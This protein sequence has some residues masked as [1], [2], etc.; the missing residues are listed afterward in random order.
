M[1]INI[2][3]SVRLGNKDF[4]VIDQVVER[5]RTTLLQINSEDPLRVTLSTNYLLKILGEC[6]GESEVDMGSNPERDAE[7]KL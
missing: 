3:E 6:D 1:K 5:G 2:G 4:V 7:E